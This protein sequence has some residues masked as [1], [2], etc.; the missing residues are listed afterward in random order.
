VSKFI[1]KRAIIIGAGMGGLAAAGALA[2]HFEQVLV[3]ER[4]TLPVEP[5]HRSGT[6]Q[7]KHVHIL[8]KGGALALEQL[9]P[10]FQN[11]LTKAGSVVVDSPL[12]SRIERSGYDPFPQRKLDLLV[13]CATRPLI[14]FSLRQ[15]LKEHPNVTVT[16]GQRVQGIV[17]T[18]DGTAATGVHCREANGQAD[19]M[20]ADLIIDASGRGVLTLDLLK[21]L[22]RPLPAETTIGMD[23][24]YSTACFVMPDG[25]ARDWQLVLT[26][27]DAPKSSRAGFLCP[28]ENNQWI[29]TLAGMHGEKPPGDWD[30]FLSFARSL[31]TQTIYE[32]IAQAQRIGQIH[33]FAMPAS[34]LR[35]FERLDNFPRGLLPLGDAICRFNPVFGQGMSV[36]ALEASSLKRL[37]DASAADADPLAK[38]ATAYF[39]EVHEMLK[40]PWS[41]ANL[42]LVFPETS[43]IRPPD[44]ERTLKFGAG[45]L[46]LAARDP[47]VHRLMLE[48]SHL[49][50]PSSVYGAP[51]FVQ[52]VQAAMQDGP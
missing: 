46:R 28:S 19:A 10:G 43:G 33:R 35:H 22:G 37:L 24:S 32:A 49:L 27:A 38:L 18:P 12:A 17:A 41:V 2:D 30:G 47:E 26:A 23:M 36:A 34:I 9:F 44:L 48:V 14:E 31:R 39:A 21:S 52:R 13:C 6:P 4:D 51:D 40:T 1:G 3:L 20:D 7:S 11:D 15:K 50:K 29:V 42:D 8:L 5:I 16:H 45:V 25:L